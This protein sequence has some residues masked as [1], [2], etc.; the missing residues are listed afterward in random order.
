MSFSFRRAVHSF[1]SIR[2]LDKSD[3]GKKHLLLSL[4][5][6]ASNSDLFSNLSFY[7][8][9]KSGKMSVAKNNRQ[10]Q[11]QKVGA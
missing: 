4:R 11:T 2:D 10:C 1:F 5:F 6:S 3:K 8:K 9:K 7:S